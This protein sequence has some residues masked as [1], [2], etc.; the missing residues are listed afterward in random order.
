MVPRRA[1]ALQ[2]AHWHLR[3]LVKQNATYL[4][5]LVVPPSVRGCTASSEGLLE[6]PDSEDPTPLGEAAL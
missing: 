2:T 5:E 6:W 3:Y 4:S 1:E